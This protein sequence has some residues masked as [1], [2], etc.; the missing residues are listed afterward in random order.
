MNETPKIT[1]DEAIDAAL[2]RQREER[3]AEMREAFREEMIALGLV[4]ELRETT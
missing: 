4:K 3:I 1:R 2:R